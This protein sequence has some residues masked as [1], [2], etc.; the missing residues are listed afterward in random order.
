MNFWYLPSAIRYFKDSSG[1]NAN[2]MDERTYD[3]LAKYLHDSDAHALI[4]DDLRNRKM[5]SKDCKP[6]CKWSKEPS[7]KR[8][9]CVSMLEPIKAG[10]K[11]PVSR[12]GSPWKRLPVDTGEIIGKC[13]IQYL[14]GKASTK[15]LQEEGLRVLHDFCGYLSYVRSSYSTKDWGNRFIVGSATEY[16]FAH[17]LHKR[18]KMYLCTADEVRNDVYVSDQD[19]HV[20]TTVGVKINPG[21]KFEYSLKYAK[22]SDLSPNSQT[23]ELK[24]PNVIMIN[25]GRSGKKKGNEEKIII[26]EDIFLI[27][28]NPIFAHGSGI[29][30]V[31][32][33]QL[34]EKDRWAKNG[35]S[36]PFCGKLVF[37][38]KRLYKDRYDLAFKDGEAQ[39]ELL[40]SFVQA[41]VT[42][43][44][45]YT[46]DIH[47][48]Y[49]EGK[50]ID[51]VR[52]LTNEA[53]ST[54]DTDKRRPVQQID[55]TIFL[56]RR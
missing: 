22:P 25:Y 16:L 3:S 48:P 32:N 53:M 11:K 43:H 50:S 44:P 18:F 35:V 29:K 1:V 28:P 34:N 9:S 8:A 38:P 15:V 14:Q 21:E 12:P 10:V 39:L 45:E 33:K 42:E 17:C 27:I 49:F 56:C 47:V 46:C 51:S 54:H 55:D 23:K 19:K 36:D 37:L 20:E 7:T 4:S 52:N 24:Y 2:A 5:S 31:Y 13:I 26:N 40:G 6:P 41:Y 30:K